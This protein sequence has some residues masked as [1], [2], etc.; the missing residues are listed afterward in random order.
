MR[1]RKTAR[2]AVILLSYPTYTFA[3]AGGPVRLYLRK[4]RSSHICQ[5]H[6]FLLLIAFAV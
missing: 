6:D 5:G 4:F 2:R 3:V 1:N